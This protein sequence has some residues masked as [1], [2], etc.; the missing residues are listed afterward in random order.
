MTPILKGLAIHTAILVLATASASY[1]WLRD[2]APAA[3][4]RRDVVVWRGRGADVDRVEYSK[5]GRHVVLE[6][7]SD[8]TGRY[9]IGNAESQG[10]ADAGVVEPG[11]TMFVSVGA[12]QKIADKVGE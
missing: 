10:G 9:Y 5:P 11:K 1:V 4:V 12:A 2:K 7:K 8:A 6:G 3:S